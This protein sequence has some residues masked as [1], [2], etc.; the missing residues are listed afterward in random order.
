MQKTTVCTNNT[1]KKT[2]CAEK[3]HYRNQ[4]I[5]Q[6]TTLYRNKHCAEEQHCTENN[7]MQKTPQCIK[8]T[9]MQKNQNPWTY[10]PKTAT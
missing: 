2:H 6:K 5:M 4:P 8:T 9:D 3:E 7:T 10:N 1:V